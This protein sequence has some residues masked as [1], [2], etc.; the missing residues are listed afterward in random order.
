M[1]AAEAKKPVY[2]RLV[3]ALP[4]SVPF[5][6]PE[7]LERRIGRTLALRI[8]A[9]ESAFGPSPKAQAAIR[10]GASKVNWYCDP[11]G[12]VLREAL[13]KHH[14]VKRDNIGLGIGIDD[15]LGLSV[16][17]FVDPGDPVVM[18]YGAYPTFAFHVAGFG[19]RFVYAPYRD[20]RNDPE[21]LADVAR[22]NDSRLVYLSNPD[23]PTGS[24]LDAETQLRL[25]RALPDHAV[26]LLDE[27]YSDFAPAGTVPEIDPEDP[28]VIRLRTFSKAHGM[29]GMRIGYAIA[30]VEVIAAFDK[31]RH[32]FGVSRLAQEAAL[33]SLGDPD[34]IAQVAREVSVGR[35]DYAALAERLG[36]KALPSATNF[37]AID[38][39]SG[40]RARATL[41]WLLE[42]EA[43]FLRMP[44][45]EPL[46]RLIRVTV[47]TEAERRGFA[48]ALA[49]VLPRLPA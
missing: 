18:S 8:G 14:G 46:D 44:G 37:V 29:A 31:I 2:S 39:G 22:K 10:D 12:F 35:A 19:G 47:G 28:R 33:A 25:I 6:P 32:H 42:D 36:L 5:V 34:F 4:A 9:N 27:A 20:F 24:W 7:A 21:A 15:L 40:V 30:P 11:E 17:A 26:M 45:V 49:R 13:A 1:S 16:R 48:A 38:M 41:K 23:N 3:G 43:C